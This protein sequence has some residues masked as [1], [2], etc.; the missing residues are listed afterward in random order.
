M[1]MPNERKL[2]GLFESAV[3]QSDEESENQSDLSQLDRDLSTRFM[4]GDLSDVEKR[5]PAMLKR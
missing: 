2:E 3:L 4:A 1:V 5:K